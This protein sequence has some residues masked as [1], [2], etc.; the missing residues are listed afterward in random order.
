[1]LQTNEKQLTGYR[2]VAVV[3]LATLVSLTAS[4]ESNNGQPAKADMNSVWVPNSVWTRFILDVSKENN[5]DRPC[6]GCDW[7]PSTIGE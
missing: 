3:L 1:M 6:T 7:T 5:V 4:S 2:A